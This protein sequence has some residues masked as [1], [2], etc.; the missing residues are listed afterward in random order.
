[1]TYEIQESLVVP[2][3]PAEVYAAVSDVT[4]T[5]EW[6]P[7]CRRCTWDSDARGVGARF[8]GD[9]R[10]SEREWSTTSEVVAVRATTE[11]RS[12]PT[13]GSTTETNTV[14]SGQ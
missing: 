9:N 5:G 2:V 14:P 3:P 4:R 11:R 13:P 10:T 12:E 6:S 7:Q 8:T 1:M